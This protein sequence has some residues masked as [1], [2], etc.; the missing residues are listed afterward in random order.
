[1]PQIFSGALCNHV[2]G[3]TGFAWGGPEYHVEGIRKKCHLKSGDLDAPIV[4]EHIVS[5]LVG[6]PTPTPVVGTDCAMM[7]KDLNGG[8]QLLNIEN[9]E[10]WQ[11]CGNFMNVF[12]FVFS[13]LLCIMILL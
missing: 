5:G 6:C 12:C 1:M 4:N 3:C 13:F 8:D 2:I 7:D 10:K 11:D 9:V